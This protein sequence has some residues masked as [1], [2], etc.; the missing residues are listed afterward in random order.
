MADHNAKLLDL[1][2][3]WY[4]E[5]CGSLIT[6]PSSKFRNSKWRIQYGGKKIQETTGIWMK[7]GTRGT[8]R[9]KIKNSRSNTVSKT[10][11]VTEFRKKS[12]LKIPD[13][14][15]ELKSEIK[16]KMKKN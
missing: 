4:S 15:S 16:N 9:S 1:D 3:I 13:S 8:Q 10:Q 5:V 14:K 2:G 7:L 11:K 12:V 6:S